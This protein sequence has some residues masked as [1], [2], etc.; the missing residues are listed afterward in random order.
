MPWLTSG[1]RERL[2][3]P[4]HRLPDPDHRRLTG[5]GPDQ[6][7]RAARHGLRPGRAERGRQDVAVQLRVRALPALGRDG[8]ARRHRR[9]ADAAAPAG[10]AR[11]GPHVPARRCCSRTRPCWPTC[12]SA[13]TRAA[14]RPGSRG[15]LCA[16]RVV[17]RDERWTAE[18]AADARLAR[19]PGLAGA[20][21]P[22]ALPYGAMKRVELA[23]ALLAH[24]RLL[25][26]D[27]LA[28]G[29]CT[30][31]WTRSAR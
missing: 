23:R 29:W 22:A 21:R 24:P 16:G 10:R 19:S 4:A 31:R 14:A 9:A 15:T 30:R 2:R 28:S 17:R 12:C 5:A 27:E 26:L 20:A 7:V 8:P 6:H 13:G 25:L 11:R 1:R 3:P 18:A